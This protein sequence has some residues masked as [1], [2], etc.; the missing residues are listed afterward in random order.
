MPVGADKHSPMGGL[1]IFF[2]EMKGRDARSFAFN[3]AVYIDAVF[4]IDRF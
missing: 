2:R 4:H 1:S 3:S